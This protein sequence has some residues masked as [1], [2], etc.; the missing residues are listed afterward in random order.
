MGNPWKMMTTDEG[1]AMDKRKERG[2][3]R[4]QIAIKRRLL[5]DMIREH[6]PADRSAPIRQFTPAEVR[7]LFTRAG[8]Q[9]IA[10]YPSAVLASSVRAEMLQQACESPEGF[11]EAVALEERLREEPSLLGCGMDIQFVARRQTTGP[12][13]RAVEQ[14]EQESER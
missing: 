1:R 8:W 5:W 9:V 13:G 14:I 12:D 6:L 4:F 7:N 11:K 10:M 3:N 2:P